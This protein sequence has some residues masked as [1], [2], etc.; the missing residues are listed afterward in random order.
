MGD[1]IL[2]GRAPSNF[3]KRRVLKYWVHGYDASKT[4]LFDLDP[5]IIVDDPPV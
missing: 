4:P 2:W 5:K 3:G 1:T